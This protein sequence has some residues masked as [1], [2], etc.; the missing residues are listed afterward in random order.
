MF[1]YEFGGW[2]V[3]VQLFRSDRGTVKTEKKRKKVCVFA[4]RGQKHAKDEKWG[5][6]IVSGSIMGVKS[7]T[8][9][10]V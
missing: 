5:A 3:Y 9:S 4:W 10:G 6:F 7:R 1:I 2:M 8:F